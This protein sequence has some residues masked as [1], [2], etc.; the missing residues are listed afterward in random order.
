MSAHELLHD[1]LLIRTFEQHL[2][3]RRDHGF[4]LFSS[5]EEAVSVGL[6]SVLNRD[7]QLLC[8]GRAIGPALARGLEPGLVLAELL[9]KVAGPCRGRAGRG[10][11]ALP[12]QGFF[13]AHAVVG[14][15]LTIAAGVALA[16]QSEGNQN[17]VACMFGDGACGAGALHET[18]NI[19][20][21]WHLPLLLVC[22][23][24]QYSVSTPRA[25]ALAPQKLSDLAVPFGMPALTV[26]GMDVTAVRDATREFSDHIR[27]GKG[28]A[29]LECISYRFT[30]HSTSARESRP[31]AEIEAIQA[32][33]PIVRLS[34]Q[35]L[36]DGEISQAD[37]DQMKKDVNAA[38]QAASVFA[39]AAAFPDPAEV[40]HDIV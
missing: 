15:N 11:M 6:C 2:I 5:G 20:A 4:Q 9:G 25:A 31:T 40:L 26:D 33:C 14:G 36:M 39:E 7:D 32:L 17:L 24:N 12:A 30:P 23:N 29:F 38:V 27:A 1:M 21:L 35:M 22:N 10:H 34:S 28:P 8:S 37:L 3:K 13:G 19:A 16:M 18:L